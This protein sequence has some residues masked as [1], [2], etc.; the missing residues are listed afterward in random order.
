MSTWFYYD[1]NGQKQGPITGGQ[2]K[3]L[4]KMGQITPETAIETE[5]GKQCKASRIN[6]LQFSSSPPVGT[7]NSPSKTTGLLPVVA[8]LGGVHTHTVIQ[9]GISNSRAN[10]FLFELI[11]DDK[12]ITVTKDFGLASD[13][14]ASNTALSRRR[15]PYSK[16]QVLETKGRQLA[17]RDLRNPPGAG[18]LFILSALITASARQQ[19]NNRGNFSG[20]IDPIAGYF[21]FDS[22]SSSKSLFSSF[23]DSSRIEYTASQEKFA[24]VIRDFLE[25]KI[26]DQDAMLA[27]QQ[28]YN[29]AQHQPGYSMTSTT[30]R[31]GCFGMVL[32]AVAIFIGISSAGIALASS[33]F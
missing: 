31:Q 6:G 4:A 8:R 2:L 11:I 29:A 15:I 28:L 1:N 12:G 23:A 16:M 26:S 21:L 14:T 20:D 27:E 9:T 22:A 30:H 5:S 3:G 24:N 33:L 17:Q 18:C 10:Y 7:S 32:I 25:L 19:T 13:Y